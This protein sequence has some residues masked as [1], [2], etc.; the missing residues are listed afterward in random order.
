MWRSWLDEVFRPY[1]A[2]CIL[3]LLAH[4]HHL[5]RLHRPSSWL[6]VTARP[7]DL[8]DCQWRMTCGVGDRQ[9]RGRSRSC[10]GSSSRTNTAVRKCHLLGNE[11]SESRCPGVRDFN[12]NHHL[13]H[14][15]TF[16]LP[17]TTSTVF[18]GAW[19]HK[20][21][22][23][24]FEQPCR[25][26]DPYRVVRR[27]KGSPVAAVARLELKGSAR[28]VWCF[29]LSYFRTPRLRFECWVAWR[30]LKVRIYLW[31]LSLGK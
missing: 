27:F 9:A 16:G 18:G 5:H 3:S 2:M 28:N 23:P 19:V 29:A 13:A 14:H 6:T 17:F 8:V 12:Q 25:S 11:S 20:L 21:V 22:S 30:N 7:A 1:P 15:R 4:Y 31:H 24:P 10:R 26:R